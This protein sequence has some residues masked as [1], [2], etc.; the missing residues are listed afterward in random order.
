MD[1]FAQ[2]RSLRNSP[3][4]KPACRGIDASA[5]R[6]ARI[7]GCPWGFAA[8]VTQLITQPLASC[9]VSGRWPLTL[10]R[11]L[12]D[13]WKTITAAAMSTWTPAT[14]PP[15]MARAPLADLPVARTARPPAGVNVCL[16]LCHLCWR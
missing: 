10:N 2:S 5:G 3:G 8:I 1:S 11:Q 16:V 4:V 9:Q 14:T 7:R 12:G 15:I 13:Q 6:Y